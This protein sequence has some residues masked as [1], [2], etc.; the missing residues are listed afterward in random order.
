MQYKFYLTYR[1]SHDYEKLLFQEFV[2]SCLDRRIS[3][4]TLLRCAEAPG[5]AYQNLACN[6]K[7]PNSLLLWTLSW[8][9]VIM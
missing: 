6:V 5:S 2:V 9:T 1:Q 8:R 7:A 3:P 4:E